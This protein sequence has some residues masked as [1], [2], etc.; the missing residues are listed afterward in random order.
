MNNKSNFVLTAK[1]CVSGGSLFE[2]SL[3]FDTKNCSVS[4]RNNTEA[5]AT[6]V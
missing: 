3:Q 6:D 1:A 2:L 4:A 5:S